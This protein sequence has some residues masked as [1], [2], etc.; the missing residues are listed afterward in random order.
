M[1]DKSGDDK[2]KLADEAKRLTKVAVEQDE[3]SAKLKAAQSEL[4]DKIKSF[5]K[6][7]VSFNKDREAFVVAQG[8]PIGIGEIGE[9]PGI[10]MV[11]EKD[12][13]EVS[14][15]EAFMN[16]KVKVY[17]SPD[18]TQGALDIVVVTVNGIN[19]PIIRGKE[20]WIKRK[21][22]EALARS[23]ITTYQQQTPDPTKPDVIQMID[24][25]SITYPFAVREDPN[26]RGWPWLSAILDQPNV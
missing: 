3:I 1:A 22:V 12:F 23:R 14:K 4:D 15:M 26:P 24:I 6:R 21:Y 18:G 8:K 7:L 25:T 17:L 10:E 13:I 5:E 20:Q 19:Q 11:T 9:S 16:E 2:I